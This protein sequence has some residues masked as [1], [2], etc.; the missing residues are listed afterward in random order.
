MPIFNSL[1]DRI[2]RDSKYLQQTLAPAAEFDDFTVRSN[3]PAITPCTRGHGNPLADVCL[4]T[5]TVCAAFTHAPSA[6]KLRELL[7]AFAFSPTTQKW[8]QLA[9]ES[10]S[11]LHLDWEC[12]LPCWFW[13]CTS[14]LTDDDLQANLL[15]IHHETL[16][17]RESRA[18]QQLTLGIHRSDYMLD[19]PSN[20][21]MQVIAAFSMI[22]S[23]LFTIDPLM[24]AQGP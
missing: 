15:R 21:L 17:L 7:P 5:P 24:S 6:G 8:S 9:S 3:L 23:C 18:A 16:N 13:S 19:D 10:P 1:I 4:L 12:P 22:I 14:Q 20:T 2:S 11:M